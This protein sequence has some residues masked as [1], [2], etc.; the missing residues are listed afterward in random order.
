MRARPVAPGQP[1][2]GG[3]GPQPPP[4]RTASFVK[5]KRKRKQRQRRALL[6]M[7]GGGVLVLALAVFLLIRLFGTGKEDAA[8]SAA[9]A[10][11]STAQA[12]ATG[13]VDG[14]SVSLPALDMPALATGPY[15]EAEMPVLFNF[16]NAIPQAYT[17]ALLNGGMVDVGNGQ[18]MEERAAA[19][20]L[21]MVAAAKADGVSLTALSGYR[22]NERQANNYNASI[23]R[24]L[25]QGYSPDEAKR[26]TEGYYAIPGT[27]EHEAGLAMDIGDAGVP[28]ANIQDS[29]EKTD[30]FAWLQEHAG[31][32]GFILRYREED[33]D[34]TH[35]HYE[36]WHYRYVGANHAAA[37]EKQG[38]TLEEYVQGG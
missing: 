30:A 10:P 37:I 9:P 26:R 2:Q 6:L 12:A 31:E 23:E 17:D 16:E 15:D 19:A 29:F 21:D 34:T 38:V 8:T 20:Y 13:A 27:S 14:V 32:Y 36:P 1:R 28:S 33:F 3:R 18:K 7:L 25:A 11:A 4:R 5:A 35:I 22:S 24:Y